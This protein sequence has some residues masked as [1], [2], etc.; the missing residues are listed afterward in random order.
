MTFSS[1]SDPALE[2]VKILGG[3]RFVQVIQP[4]PEVI[5]KHSL[6]D[7]ADN[8]PPPV[9]FPALSCAIGIWTGNDRH[10]SLSFDEFSPTAVNC[11][12]S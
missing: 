2:F 9:I 7:N 1:Q 5:C 6:I 3:Y 8:P 4:F 11:H 12:E 10:I